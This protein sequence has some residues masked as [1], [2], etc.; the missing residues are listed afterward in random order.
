M[1][2]N[3]FEFL[4]F[5]PLVTLAYFLL[6]ARLKTPWLL[7]ASYYFYMGWNARY[8]VLIAASTLV[9]YLSGLLIE[10]AGENLRLKRLWV[11]L[12]LLIN[13][14]ILFFFKYA[15]F[16]LESLAQVLAALHVRLALPVVDV[17]LP[18]GISF[19]TFQALSYTLDVYRGEIEAEHDLVKYALFV[20]F[21]PQLVAGPIERSR[22]LLRQVG[23]HK[24]FEWER[25]KYGLGL[26]LWGYLE[27][28]VI[29]DRIAI[30]VDHVFENYEACGGATLAAGIVLFAIE[31]YC[32]FGGYSHIAIGAAQVLGFTLMDNFRQPYFALSI[33]DFWS[34]WHISLSS[35]LQDYLFTPLVWS[36][37]TQKIPFLGKKAKK[38]PVLSSLMITFLVSGLWHGAAW[39]YVVWGGLNGGYQA[40]SGLTRKSRKKWQ[41]TL[42][43]PTKSAGYRLWQR[44]CT[45]ALV[46][47][48]YV[49][50]RAETCGQ[51]LRYL[52]CAFRS[53]G[54]WNTA[55]YTGLVRADYAILLAGIL[56]LFAVDVLHEKGL[57][58]RDTLFAKPWAMQCAV[59]CGAVCFVVLF[60]LYGTKSG[61]SQFIYFQF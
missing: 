40:V 37:W 55:G 21:F 17:L 18:V 38:P 12:S 49:F 48:S 47:L 56:L 42:H 29:A 32:D 15:N 34:R 39:H 52:Q 36:K 7:V 10:R 44:L 2:F 5:F 53:P 50:F 54:V 30:F 57:R 13:L 51:A 46:C 4:A 9:T 1:L 26:M 28:M 14:G 19:Y 27:K 11:A 23:N 6:P 24:P 61:N 43:I 16:M 60:G 35:W 33:G 58:L 59:L 41:K 22:N 20:S 3:S 45:F 31:I 8:A 25:V